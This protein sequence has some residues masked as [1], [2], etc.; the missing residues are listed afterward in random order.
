[1]QR[2]SDAAITFSRAF[3]SSGRGSD[4]WPPQARAFASAAAGIL[5]LTGFLWNAGNADLSSWLES[6]NEDVG[7]EDEMHTVLNWSGTHK[8]KLPAASYHEPETLEE[9]ED[10]LRKC[11]QS[12]TPLRPIGSALSPN[13]IGFQRMGMV[14]LINLDDL[15]E[16]DVKNMTVTVQA[17][18]RVG[19]VVDALREYG[20]T[21]PNLASIAEQQMGGFVQIGAHG[22]GAKITSVDDF[23]TSLN[24][25]TPKLGT[26]TLTP[27]DGERFNL[28]KVGL[29][30]FG[31]V[32]QVTMKCVKAH[33]LVEHTFVLTRNEA[34]SQLDTLLKRHKHMRYMWIPFEDAVVVVTNDPEGMTT[35]EDS[36]AMKKPADKI[37][38]E[39]ER[40]QPFT[41]LLIE[42]STKADEPFT[43]D[44]VKGMGFGEIRD[45]LLAIDPL[46]KEHV[47][48]VNKS[49]A[50]YWRRSAGYQIKPSDQLLQ[51]DCGGQQWVWEICFPTGTLEENTGNDMAVLERILKVIED[52]DIPAPAPIEQR[53]S[54]SSS[55]LMSPSHGTPG[56]LHSWVGIIMY[57]PSDD[58]HQREA[59]TREF[60]GTYCEQLRKIGYDFNAA[61][62]WAKLEF[63]PD[64]EGLAKL[65]AFMSNRYPLDKFNALRRE[66]DPKNI[67]G[68][69]LINV[70]LGS[71]ED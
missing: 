41:D 7:D 43:K 17:G 46:D 45:A 25:V 44:S 68:N 56:G 54:A 22:T 38:S 32:S 13:G 23:V 26:I 11:H 4:G 24:I 49:E 35:K 21:L 15:I 31:I 57:L 1:M 55:S 19:Q 60:K 28:A 2:Q 47:K 16:V 14:N 30:C 12:G 50:E 37:F 69:S 48:R 58:E 63:P 6:R 64:P 59:I 34:R 27:E 36:L 8:V 67:L 39:E 66:Y 42:L 9:L 10:L 3:S 40:F 20:M 52:D 53:W 33:N 18:A 62:H 61:S 71:P 51:F 5:C 70:I 29:G 65:M